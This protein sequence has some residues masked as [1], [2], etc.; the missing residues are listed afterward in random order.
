VNKLATRIIE[1]DNERTTGRSF[2]DYP[3][4]NVGNAFAEFT[5]HKAT[6]TVA[7]L[8]T[9]AEKAPTAQKEDFMAR[10]KQASDARREQKRIENLRREQEKIEAELEQIEA[11]LFGEAATDYK[12]AAELTSKKDA[13]EER[14]MEIYEELE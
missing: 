11:D 1:I 14:L 10:K 3:V 8:S 6:H 9:E 13:L 7:S 12:K 5:H 4:F 2:I